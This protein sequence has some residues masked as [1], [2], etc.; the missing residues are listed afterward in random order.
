MPGRY[1]KRKQKQDANLMS[2]KA[3]VL[4]SKEKPQAKVNSPKA[5]T[6]KVKNTK[7]IEQKKRDARRKLMKQKREKPTS[8]GNYGMKKERRRLPR[9]PS[10]GDSFDE[11]KEKRRK[12]MTRPNY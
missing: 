6:P 10:P 8:S 11:I 5:E 4:Q 7:S 3:S 12:K 1:S 2:A 9:R